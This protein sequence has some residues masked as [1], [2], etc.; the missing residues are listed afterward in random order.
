MMGIRYSFR[1]VHKSYDLS[2]WKKPKGAWNTSLLRDEELPRCECKSSMWNCTASHFPFWKRPHVVLRTSDRVWN[3]A[4]VNLSQLALTTYKAWNYST[5]SVKFFGGFSLA[6]G[7]VRAFSAA[8]VQKTRGGW[9]WLA[10]VLDRNNVTAAPV[11]TSQ[12]TRG[13]TF[14]QVMDGILSRLDS[15]DNAKVWFNN[16]FYPSLPIYQN[17]LS[18]ALLR[19]YVDGKDR[20]KYGILTVTQPMNQTAGEALD[21]LNTSR[22]VM[23]RIILIMLALCTVSAG[24]S[25]FLG[26]CCIHNKRVL[27][28]NHRNTPGAHWFGGKQALP[29]G[30]GYISTISGPFMEISK[31]TC[32]SL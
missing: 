15:Q 4:G 29:C 26:L 9:Q 7:N 6:H 23:F 27:S 12:F 18:N 14:Y 11:P 17:A 21:E 19:S 32:T 25:T 20:T 2:C 8:E 16:K 30:R 1:F 24:F 28:H 13:L 22:V 3:M 10:D 31:P 5:Q